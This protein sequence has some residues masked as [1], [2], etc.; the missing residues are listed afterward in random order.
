MISKFKVTFVGNKVFID[1]NIPPL[2]YTDKKCLR[3]I[4]SEL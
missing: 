3:S 4:N 1:K 2:Y